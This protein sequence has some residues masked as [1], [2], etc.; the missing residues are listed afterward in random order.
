VIAAQ[1]IGEPGTQLTLR[2]FHTGGVAAGGDITYGLPRVEELFEAR[3]RPKGEAEISDISGVVH[4]V[5]SDGMR[6]VQV[7]KSEVRTDK[8]DI[9]GNWGIKVK[10]GD[11]IET[12]ALIASRGDQEI[13]CRH[14]G[15][16]RRRGTAVSVRYERRAEQEY[17]IPSAARILV[18]EG[19]Q[20]KAG[21]Q[22]SD[23]TK[24]PHRILQV[25]GR[26]A[27]E[28][29]ILSEI[30]K[31]Y[32]SQGVNIND[33][34]FEVIIR[35]MFGKMEIVD[36]GDSDLLP[37]DLADRLALQEINQQIIEEGGRPAKARAVLMGITKA[38][39]NTESFLSASS[40]QHTI[41][42]LAKAAIEGKEDQLLGLKENVIIG[43]LIPAGT[44]YRGDSGSSDGPI[45]SF[46]GVDIKQPMEEAPPSLLDTTPEMDVED[47]ELVTPS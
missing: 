23:G 46:E 3:K 22:L 41:K 17:D 12:G 26:E 28:I 45:E 31:V 37:G 29:Y 33:K 40:F 5:R 11:E 18:D 9:P 1:S 32:R 24:N 4:I 44:G 20:I 43:K 47:V 2:T 15:T 10:N 21:T 6:K 13:T 16:V 38:S 8:Y 35:K 14:G 27:S 34:H 30:Q 39:L 36:S 19:Q 25:L 42:V 7:V